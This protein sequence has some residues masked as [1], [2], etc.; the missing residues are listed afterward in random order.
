MKNA[1][2]CLGAIICLLF[3]PAILLQ[4]RMAEEPYARITSV[5]LQGDNVVVEVEAS[6][7]FTKITLESSTRV[8]RRAW[9]PRAVHHLEGVLWVQNVT[10]FTFTVP[11]SPALEIL[12]VRGDVSSALPAEFYQGTDEFVSGTGSGGPRGDVAV[13]APGDFSGAPEQDSGG[14]DRT[15]EESDIWKLE[16]DTLFF[17][18][19]YRGLQVMDVSNPDA[20]DLTGTFDIPAAGEQ[21]YVIDGSKVVLLARDTCSWWGDSSESRVILL[22]ASTGE[23]QFVAQLPVKGYI[24]ESR[25]VGDALYVVANSYRERP[26]ADATVA[27]TTWEWGSDIYSFDLGNFANPVARSSDWVAGYNN[28]IMATERFLVVA[29]Y[30]YG[31]NRDYASNLHL[32]DISNPDGTF[33]KLST[34]RALGMVRDKFKMNISGDVLS[35]VSRQESEPN[36]PAVVETISITDPRN[37]KRLASLRIIEDEQLHATR[38]YGDFLYVV[39][40]MQIDPLWIIDLSDPAAPEILGE[41]E[42][43]GWSTFI[44]P[45]PGQLLTIGVDNTAGW[46]TSVQLFD[47]SDPTNPSLTSKVLI[48]DSYSGSEAN[49]DE[50]AFQVLP[51]EDLVLVPFHGNVGEKWINGVQII[52]LFP[53]ELVKR[54]IIEQ[55]FQPRRATLHRERILSLSARE[56][57]TVDA[58]DRDNPEV[59]S[60]TTLSWATDHLHVVGDYLVEVDAYNNGPS[61][62]VVSMSDPSTELNSVEL[63]ELQFLGSS[64]AGNKLYVLQGRSPEFIYRDV[65]DPANPGPISTNA[66]IISVSVYDLSALPELEL[67]GQTSEPNEQDYL[68]GR[69]GALWVKENLVV[70]VNT[71]SYGWPWWWWDVPFA[72]AVDAAAAAPVGDSIGMPSFWWGGSQGQ[73]IAVDVSGDDPEIAS[74]LR[75]SG[76]DGWW[77]FSD[78]YTAN[79]LLYTSHLTSEYDPEFD[80]PVRTFQTYEN[81]QLVTKTDDPPP[82]AWVQRYYLDVIDYNDPEDPLL[83]KPVNI[84]GS[85]IGIHKQGELLFTRGQDLMRDYWQG[86]E[87]TISASAYDGVSAS[88]VDSITIPNTWPKPAEARDGYVYLGRPGVDQ[89]KDPAIELWEVS[90]EGE[91]SLANS[92]ALE[93]PANQLA[94]YG[95][96]LAVQSSRIDLFDASAPPALVKVGSGS[97]QVCYGV[98]LDAG[99]GSVARGLWLPLGWYGV[100]HI[101]VDEPNE[102]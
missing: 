31:Q 94:F 5:V 54:G 8:G 33:E 75:L 83:R 38:F 68:Y 24:M 63:G 100:I 26:S 46:R 25:L 59:V 37:P 56:L 22:D 3:F 7:A 9:E 61:L 85:L 11:I 78:S 52:D 12:R 51:E 73:F 102:D 72:M 95:D 29:Q 71:Q 42:I 35:V 21:M 97:P 92:V 41:L 60:S 93:T 30:N 53:D 86:G 23:P 32:Y 64:V 10:T 2:G 91:F 74:M 57:L 50:K 99:D 49:Q 27:G 88:L 39:T 101:P 81:G 13:G 15:V 45:M 69:F 66:G 98:G 28:V 87:E 65:W 80:P 17:F 84:P 6:T 19:Q 55:D 90:A 58:T 20:P 44:Y 82:G 96:L 62:R 14:E 89:K 76:T 34:T 36:R 48:G 43:P 4:A 16:G 70:W 18:N 79:G 47:V 1:R 67:L 77:N 40:F